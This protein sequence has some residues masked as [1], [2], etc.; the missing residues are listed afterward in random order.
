MRILFLD[1]WRVV[2]ELF[3]LITKIVG[4]RNVVIVLFVV[5]IKMINFIF[6]K[7]ILVYDK[8][9]IQV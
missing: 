6:R 2:K 9:L 1:R 8:Q 5:K 3:M 7:N 4:H